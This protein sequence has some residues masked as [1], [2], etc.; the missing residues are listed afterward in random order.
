MQRK[1]I[2]E[3]VSDLA[4][5]DEQLMDIIKNIT[6]VKQAEV[7]QSEIMEDEYAEN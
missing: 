4:I 1:V 5:S 6:T 7:L 3:L 2:L